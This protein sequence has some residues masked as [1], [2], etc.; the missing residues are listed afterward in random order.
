M[1]ALNHFMAN[2]TVEKELH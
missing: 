2:V 1:N